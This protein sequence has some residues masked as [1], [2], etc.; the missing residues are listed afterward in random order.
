MPHLEI[1]EIALIHC[2]FVSSKDSKVLYTFVHNKSFG[3]LLDISPKNYVFLKT[4]NSEF[5][6]ID[7][8]FTD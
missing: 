3:E 6:Y 8:W 1:T 2:N 7:V 4:F 5:S